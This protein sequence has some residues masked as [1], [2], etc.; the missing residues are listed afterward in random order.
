MTINPQLRR[1]RDMRFAVQWASA[2]FIV[3]CTLGQTVDP[4]HALQSAPQYQ[5]PYEAR[6]SRQAVLS[7]IAEP[8]EQPASKR[9]VSA[10][11]ALALALLEASTLAIVATSRG[12]VAAL[13]HVSYDGGP[14]SP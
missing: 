11:A 9:N 1:K 12:A 8:E 2:L 5:K 13:S 14:K 3:C 6:H 7:F 4:V 10:L